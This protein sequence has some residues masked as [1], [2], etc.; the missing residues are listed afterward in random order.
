MQDYASALY[1]DTDMIFSHNISTLFGPTISDGVLYVVPEMQHGGV[2]GHSHK[3]EYFN[4]NKYSEK[5]MEMFKSKGIFPFNSGQLLFRVDERIKSHFAA[6]R[7]WEVE[8][9]T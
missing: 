3:N 5:D 4:V 1:V 7:K 6:V 9:A 2:L 8:L